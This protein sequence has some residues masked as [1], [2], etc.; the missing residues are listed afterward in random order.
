MKSLAGVLMFIKRSAVESSEPM[1]IRR[2][3]SRHPVQD[4]AQSGSVACVDEA[5]EFP[6]CA[7]T[8]RRC[9]ESDRLIS[10]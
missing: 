2:K 4:K 3:V 8:D 9:V 7:V 5:A 1:L 10:P 6:R